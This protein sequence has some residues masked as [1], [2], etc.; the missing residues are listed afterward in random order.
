MITQNQTWARKYGM[1]G[2][3]L[4]IESDVEDTKESEE[5]TE[6]FAEILCSSAISR[7]NFKKIRDEK[8]IKGD[9]Q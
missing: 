8:W 1:E 4:I 7:L 3:K 6:L 5:N 9:L 2:M